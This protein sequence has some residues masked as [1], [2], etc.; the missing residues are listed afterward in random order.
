M[1]KRLFIAAV[2]AGAIS[3]YAAPGVSQPAE[4]PTGRLV[5]GLHPPERVAVV[6]VRTG[7]TV[8][9]PL[10]GGTLCH[11]EIH[12]LGGRLV[13]PGTTGRKGAAVWVDLGL[14]ARPRALAE[15][16]M[17]VPSATPGRLWVA[18]V[19]R[20]RRAAA[21]RSLR[22]VTVTGHTTFVAPR[23]PPLGWP[24]LG[25]ATADGL[26]F[27]SDGRLRVWDPRRAVVTRSI[28]GGFAL[29]THPERFAWCR[30]HC[31]KVQVTD[32]RG[33][34]VFALPGRGAYAGAFSPDGSR[35]AAVQG[36]RIAL[37]DLAAGSVRYVPHARV[38]A[39]GAIAWAPSG[40]WLFFAGRHGGLLAYRPG[41]PRPL[42]LPGRVRGNVLSIAAA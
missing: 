32:R 8:S 30:G 7:R 11:G 2:V 26:V 34:R 33:D 12:V 31:S 13:F 21:M 37:V 23:L 41:D 24:S 39:A 9:R 25:G 16:H 36:G 15:A 5:L 35:L 4:R 17:F 42:V 19:T 20:G 14:R 10:A 18:T 27:E 1:W 22:E 6:D 40:R 29:A 3:L 28:P 38:A